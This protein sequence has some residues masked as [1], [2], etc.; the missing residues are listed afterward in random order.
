MN[1]EVSRLIYKSHGRLHVKWNHTYS[2]GSRK[3]YILQIWKFEALN[4]HNLVR[5]QMQNVLW[6][7]DLISSSIDDD[8]GW[9]FFEWAAPPTTVLLH[10]FTNFSFVWPHGR[11]FLFFFFFF[12]SFLSFLF[13]F[14]FFFQA[15]HAM[16][17]II[18][19]QLEFFGFYF[20]TEGQKNQCQ[21]HK[22]Q[23]RHTHVEGEA[24]HLGHNTLQHIKLDVQEHLQLVTE[25][26]SSKTSIW[27]PYCDNQSARGIKGVCCVNMM[28][29]N[30]DLV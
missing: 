26:I 17:H 30:K 2:K 3:S 9:S 12:P 28:R 25:I 18:S 1:L 5:N 14:L 11:C 22:N 13:F 8:S 20:Q 6:Q 4:A 16:A 23:G 10:I 27:G 15:V 19:I 21:V 24:E 29:E 7:M